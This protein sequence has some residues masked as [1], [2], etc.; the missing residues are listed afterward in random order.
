VNLNGIDRWIGGVHLR[1]RE[2]SWRWADGTETIVSV[3]DDPRP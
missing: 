2:T 1:G 3:A